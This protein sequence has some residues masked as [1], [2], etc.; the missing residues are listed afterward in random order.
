[1]ADLTRRHDLDLDLE[2]ERIEAK[3]AFASLA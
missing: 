2:F 1:M 3:Y